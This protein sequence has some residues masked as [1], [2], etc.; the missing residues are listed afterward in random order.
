MR[1]DLKIKIAILD[2]HKMMATLLKHSLRN[3]DFVENIYVFHD[4][5]ISLTSLNYIVLTC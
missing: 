1:N 3:A 2:D 4:T 5:Q